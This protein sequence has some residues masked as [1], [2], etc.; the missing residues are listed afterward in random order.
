MTVI[1]GACVGGGLFLIILLCVIVVVLRRRKSSN[2]GHQ[3]QA[4]PEQPQQQQ[5]QKQ[6][7]HKDVTEQGYL[8]DH[9]APNS[10][11]PVAPLTDDGEYLQ[12]TP[13]TGIPMGQ[14]AGDGNYVNDHMTAKHGTP[15]NLTDNGDYLHTTPSNQSHQ[16]QGLPEQPQPQPQQ[17]QSTHKDVTEQDYLNDHMALN[18]GIPVSPL[19]DDGDYLQPTPD[20]GIPMGQMA[21]DGNDMNDHQ[22]AKHGTHF[23]LTDNGDYLHTTPSNQS[24][25]QQGLPEQPQTQTQQQ[26]S[27]HKD[28]TEQDYLNDHMAPNSGIPVSPL[29]DDGNYLRPTPDTG[30]PMGQ[31]A[32]DGNYV[33]DH[34]AATH[35]TP[36]N[37]TDNGDYLHTATVEGIPMGKMADNGDNVHMTSKGTNFRIA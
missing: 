13:D 27:T 1:I 37:L 17:Q 2:Q 29:T 14:T 6:S 16:Q 7:T 31:T 19:T 9:M 30:I 15:F 25:Q 11:I 34:M 26:Q 10:G 28:V 8:N 20:T 22:T 32:G 12:P 3:Q 23:S 18:S 21:A 36:F 33:N 35:G 4:L 5:Q 24:H